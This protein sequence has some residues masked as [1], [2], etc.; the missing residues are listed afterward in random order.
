MPNQLAANSVRTYHLAT[1]GFSA[2]SSELLGQRAG[3]L[4]GVVAFLLVLQYKEFGD[5]WR[6]GSIVS[7]LPSLFLI[8][9]LL[10]AMVPGVRNGLK[11]NRQSWDSYELVIG[12]D[13]LIRR[14]ADFPDLEI[15]R[16]E[17]TV[18]KESPKGLRVQ[19]KLR[20]RS[21]GIASALVGYEDAKERLS[22]WGVPWQNSGR[23]RVLA[24]GIG[25]CPHACSSSFRWLL[26]SY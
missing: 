5:N 14:I 2:A 23:G 16:H 3:L 9:F 1:E 8:L 12:E 24:A 18:I 15:Q 6:S 25:R 7:F 13:F 11:R 17:V 10:G 26:P 21:I 22:S 4:I 20:D 19:T